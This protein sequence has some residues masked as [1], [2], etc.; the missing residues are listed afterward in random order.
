MKYSEFEKQVRMEESYSPQYHATKVSARHA[1]GTFALVGNRETL[2]TPQALEVAVKRVK[3]DLFLSYYGELHG[4]L[5]RLHK[6]LRESDFPL[7]V[8]AEEEMLALIEDTG[9]KS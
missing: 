2:D 1:R 4:R 9:V 7:P 8:K 3:R 6:A 5:V